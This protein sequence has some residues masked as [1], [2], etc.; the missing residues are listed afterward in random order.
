MTKEEEEREDSQACAQEEEP[1]EVIEVADEGEML[2]IKRAMSGQ[3]N[4][5]E[6]QRENLFHSRCTVK[7]V[8]ESDFSRKVWL[9]IQLLLKIESTSCKITAKREHDCPVC[10][11]GPGEDTGPV[12]LGFG[13]AYVLQ[14]GC[15]W[16]Y[17]KDEML[18]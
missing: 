12:L 16:S 13:R 9:P 14:L 2:M 11:I 4:E 1:E 5:Q 15:N 10:W 3:K 8:L 18:S 6:E 17:W 7:L